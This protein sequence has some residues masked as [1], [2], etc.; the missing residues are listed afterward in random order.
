MLQTHQGTQ[1]LEHRKTAY[2]CRYQVSIHDQGTL[3]GADRSHPQ[4][5]PLIPAVAS[6]SKQKDG[7]SNGQMYR[8]N[9]SNLEKCE[10][11]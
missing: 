2:I 11:E 7:G 5:V 1:E 4:N 10:G 6:T 8:K 3:A 9:T